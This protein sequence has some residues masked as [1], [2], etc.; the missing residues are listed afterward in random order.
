M[1]TSEIIFCMTSVSRIATGRCRPKLDNAQGTPGKVNKHLGAEGQA[2]SELVPKAGVD[3]WYQHL[4][5][6]AR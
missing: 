3:S 5:S 1:D 2:S 6:I 4:T